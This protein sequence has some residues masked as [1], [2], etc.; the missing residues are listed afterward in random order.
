MANFGFQF[1][2]RLTHDAAFSRRGAS[3]SGFD[4]ESITVSVGGF[5]ANG[6]PSRMFLPSS[7]ILRAAP[8][9]EMLPVLFFAPAPPAR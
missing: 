4:A 9:S 3:G 1:S 5:L 2:I 7:S 6:F 8:R